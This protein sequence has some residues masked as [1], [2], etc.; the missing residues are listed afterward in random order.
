MGAAGLST[1]C[2]VPDVAAAVLTD[3]LGFTVTADQLWPGKG[4]PSSAGQPAANGLDAATHIDDLVG[5]LSRLAATSPTP[6]SPVDDASG[7]DLTATVLDQLHR[8]VVV[9]R[10][11][12]R[13][14]SGPAG[15]GRAH[16]RAR[17]GVAQ[18][19]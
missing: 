1:A 15:T 3:R 16:R 18:A 17:R 6:L 4:G 14:R 8:A 19:R 2:P 5:E 9:A 12:A 11:P 10:H 13:S 7:A